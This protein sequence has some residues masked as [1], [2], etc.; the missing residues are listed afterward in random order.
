M[1]LYVGAVCDIDW[2]R[3]SISFPTTP[4][5]WR[6]LTCE[7][8]SDAFPNT[9][10]A[11]KQALSDVKNP[12]RRARDNRFQ[13]LSYATTEGSTTLNEASGHRAAI[14]GRDAFAQTFPHKKSTTGHYS[15]RD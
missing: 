7:G 4:I 9:F 13:A 2:S 14:P 6:F 5:A 12:V 8:T 15:K 10:N 1:V 3:C 11:R